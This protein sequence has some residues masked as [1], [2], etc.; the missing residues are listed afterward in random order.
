MDGKTLRAGFTGTHGADA[1]ALRRGLTA[2]LFGG[3][4][5]GTMSDIGVPQARFAL[6]KTRLR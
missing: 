5:R 4:H 2:K 6:V 1:L 3:A